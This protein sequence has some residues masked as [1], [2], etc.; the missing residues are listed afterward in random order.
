M[1]ILLLTGLHGRSGNT[2]WIT[3]LCYCIFQLH[4]KYYCYYYYY[5]YYKSVLHSTPYEK[6]RGRSQEQFNHHP[7]PQ[8][9]GNVEVYLKD[10]YYNYSNSVTNLE[11]STKWRS[12]K[13]KYPFKCQGTGQPL[14]GN[15]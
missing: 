3:H 9:A 13:S 1:L 12:N 14:D 5:Y 15:V 8:S 10:L 11:V 6:E 7:Q 2:E 4:Y